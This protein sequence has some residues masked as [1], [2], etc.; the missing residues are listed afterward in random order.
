MSKDNTSA[1]SI[2]DNMRNIAK[3]E[4]VEKRDAIKRFLQNATLEDW[5]KIGARVVNLVEMV[6]NYV[7]IIEYNA[8]NLNCDWGNPPLT[9]IM[10]VM[11][12][13]DLIV[14]VCRVLLWLMSD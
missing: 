9:T 2:I 4:F 13:S 11:H 12:Y 14:P 10:D 7:G 1:K 6:N 8:G 5:I 3:S